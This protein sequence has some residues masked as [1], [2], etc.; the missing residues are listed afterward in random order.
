[1]KPFYLMIICCT[2]LFLVGCVEETIATDEPAHSNPKENQLLEPPRLSIDIGKETITPIQGTYSWEYENNDGTMTHTS[3][4]IDGPFELANQFNPPTVKA[5][6][7]VTLSFELEPNEYS[8]R[9]LEKDDVVSS[10]DSID[11]T[12]KGKTIYEI[13][14][15]WDQGEASY[16]F[17]LHIK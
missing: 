15:Y 5:N 4:D 16:I 17:S 2:F 1:M 8:V 3:V 12:N 9:I 10:S 11:L 6:S 13:I 14:G 7:N